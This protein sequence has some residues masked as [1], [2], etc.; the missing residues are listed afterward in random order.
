[1]ADPREQEG[2]TPEELEAETA[3][4]L[5]ERAAMSTLSPA[6]VDPAAGTAEAVGDTVGETTGTVGGAAGEVSGAIPETV[7]PVGEALPGTVGEVGDTVDGVGDTAGG[8]VGGVGSTLPGTVDGVG[9]TLDGLTDQSL[10]DL[11]VN[12]DGDLDA[13]APINAGVAANAN[14]ALPVDAAVSAN[15]LSPGAES[16]AVADQAS[17]ISQNIEADAIANA[18]QDSTVEQGEQVPD[19]VPPAEEPTPGAG[20]LLDLDANVDLGLDLAAPIDAA[21]AA[22]ANIAAPIDAAVSANTLSPDATSVASASQ[23][24]VIVQNIEGT[25]QADADQ[26]SSIEQGEESP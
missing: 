25:A 3:E 8:V 1:M 7:E 23:E 13:A 10:L 2:L 6:G 22:N 20:S 24:S 16:L 17:G 21:V 14:A 26:D 9:D 11:D 15:T 19:P 12:V 5:P 4:A 18:T